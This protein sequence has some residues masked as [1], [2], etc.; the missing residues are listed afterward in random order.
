MRENGY[1]GKKTY[2]TQIATTK[3]EIQVRLAIGELKG[4]IRLTQ[5][6]GNFAKFKVL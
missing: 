4:W 6:E 5:A 3:K 1:P 2:Q